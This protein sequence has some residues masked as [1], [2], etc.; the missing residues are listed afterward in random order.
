MKLSEAIR[1]GAKMK[2]Q[3]FG[4]LFNLRGET[5]AIGAALDA[6]GGMYVSMYGSFP[7]LQKP[8]T[9]CPLCNDAKP[10]DSDV[11]CKNFG[12]VVAHINDV[13]KLSRE[14]IAEWVE[15]IEKKMETTAEVPVQGDTASAAVPE[16]TSS[17]VYPVE[18]K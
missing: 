7:I 1:A 3:A 15:V 8:I 9:E 11:P 16:K 17:E 18:V 13:H 6:V 5:C 10:A 14:A 12:Q 4:T 2:P